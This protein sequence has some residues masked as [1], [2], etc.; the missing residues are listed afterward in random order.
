MKTSRPRRDRLLLAY[1]LGLVMAGCGDGG[2]TALQYAPPEPGLRAEPKWLTFLCSRPGCT[3]TKTATIAVLGDRAVALKRVVM[4]D[5]EHPDFILQPV[6]TPVV[7]QP[8]AS[9]PVTVTHDPS[10]Q[11]DLGDPFIR[12]TFTDAS[13]VE[14]EGR[15]AAGEL[16]IPLVIR[17]VGEAR[18]VVSPETIQFGALPPGGTRTATLTLTNTGFG[19]VGLVISEATPEPSTD[20][21][22]DRLPSA[23]GPGESA[24]LFVT[25]SPS[26]EAFL[27][28]QLTLL[29]AGASSMPVAVPMLGTSLQSAK[30][31]V[32]PR[33]AVDF[34]EV[35]VGQTSTREINITNRGGQDLELGAVTLRR[36]PA[37]ADFQVVWPDGGAVDRLGPLGT[38]TVQLRLN[39]NGPA[40]VDAWVDIESADPQRSTVTLPL[41]AVLA[42]PELAIDPLTLDFGAVPQGWTKLLPV[43]VSNSGFGEL[44]FQNAGLVLGTSELFTIRNVPEFPVR[45]ARQERLAFEIEFRSE[46]AASFSGTLALETNDPEAP[47]FEVP[48]SARGASCEEGCPIRNGTPDC[49]EGICQVGAC[50]RNWHDADGDPASGCECQEPDPRG[51]VGQFCA[52]ATYLGSLKD[53]GQSASITGIIPNEGDIDTIRFHAKDDGQFLGD[54]FRVRIE[55]G[56]SDPNI[57]M[58]VYRHP[59]ASHTSECFLENEACGLRVYT[60][61]GAFARE[62]GADFVIRVFRQPGTA[63]TCTSYTIFAR[64]G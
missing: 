20:I 47:F 4:S 32:T 56:S 60:R 42:K 1:S 51:D 3:T 48:L 52:D 34:G 53:S 15:I 57:A 61:G 13:P 10:G 30:I 55:L 22:I 39:A 24:D 12:V 11:L 37:G 38:A 8:D 18:L 19:N 27:Q 28:G 29:P 58:C 54:D 23:L 59:T 41:R 7:L 44:V 14:E 45:L 21:F 46:A 17:R 31:H 62:D 26:T 43:E 5:P 25:W 63:P 40:R 64:N 49:S 9:L 50:D 33:E 6:Q 36:I 16:E 35:P 2:V